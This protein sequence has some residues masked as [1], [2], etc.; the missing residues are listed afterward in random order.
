MFVPTG[1]KI[2]KKEEKNL[3][4]P[5]SLNTIVELLVLFWIF[6]LLFQFVS[7]YYTADTMVFDGVST[8]EITLFYIRCSKLLLGLMMFPV[9]YVLMKGKSWSWNLLKSLFVIL[10]GSIGVEII[11]SYIFYKQIETGIVYYN[12][13]AIVLLSLFLYYFTRTQVKQYLLN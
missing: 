3:Q 13:P 4:R 11:A 9:I 5:F 12:L 1:G 8:G 10:I 2:M 6:W 7:I